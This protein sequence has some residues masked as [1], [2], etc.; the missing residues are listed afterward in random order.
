MGKIISNIVRWFKS[1][2]GCK[3]ICTECCKETTPHQ[4]YEYESE[5]VKVDIEINPK[6][7]PC[8]ESKEEIKIENPK[9]DKPV[10]ENHDNVDLQ[11]KQPIEVVEKIEDKQFYNDKSLEKYVINKKINEIGQSAFYGC[12]NLKEVTI[13]STKVVKIGKQAFDYRANR[14]L[15]VLPDL[16]IY[17]P[18]KMIDKYKA[19]TNWKRYADIIKPITK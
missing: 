3:C 4:K 17:V 19:D 9:V 7:E 14:K 16:T 15:A 10:A 2:F 5:N 6:E 11:P 13:K 8:K 18:E 1:L 12:T